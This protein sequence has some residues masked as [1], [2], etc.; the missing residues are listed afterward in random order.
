M[1]YA[2]IFLAFV[3]TVSFAKDAKPYTMTLTVVSAKSV[4]FTSGAGSSSATD[5]WLNGNNINCNTVDTSFGGIQGVSFY[6]LANSSDGNTYFFSCDAQ[7]RWS[8]CSGLQAGQL[9][10]AR[11][12]GGALSVEY[13]DGKGKAKEGKYRIMSMEMTQH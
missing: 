10:H 9:F 5:C 2:L 12:D 3:S 11:M 1:K 13:Y 6:M 7:W 8:K 4:P